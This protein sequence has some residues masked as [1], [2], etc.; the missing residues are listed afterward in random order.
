MIV[1]EELADEF[2][3]QEVRVGVFVKEGLGQAEVSARLSQSAG[4]SLS[5]GNDIM[6]VGGCLGIAYPCDRGPNID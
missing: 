4:R 3:L 5:Q 2:K 1:E 6:H